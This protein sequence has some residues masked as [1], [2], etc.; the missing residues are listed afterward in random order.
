MKISSHIKLKYI[1]ELSLFFFRIN[2][3]LFPFFIF[4]WNRM[5]NINYRRNWM[6]RTDKNHSIQKVIKSVSYGIASRDFSFF[7]C[8]SKNW[9]FPASKRDKITCRSLMTFD[10]NILSSKKKKEK[11]ELIPLD[12]LVSKIYTKMINLEYA[13]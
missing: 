2:F 8:R 9:T 4:L 1:F 11:I 10:R 12:F 6:F 13:T 3:F 5:K 7:K